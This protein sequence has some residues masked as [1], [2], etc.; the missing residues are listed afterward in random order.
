MTTTKFNRTDIIELAL[1]FK[2][3]PQSILLQIKLH[4]QNR[5]GEL[6]TSDL[7]DSVS[8]FDVAY[9]YSDQSSTWQ[10][11]NS[12]TIRLNALIKASDYSD[13]DKAIL[14]GGLVRNEKTLDAF[15]ERFPITKI[16]SGTYDAF[17]KLYHTGKYDERRLQGMMNATRKLCSVMDITGKYVDGKTAWTKHT[18]RFVFKTTNKVSLSK[19]ANKFL[20]EQVATGFSNEDIEYLNTI[21]SAFSVCVNVGYANNPDWQ[22]FTTLP[23]F[24]IIQTRISSDLGEYTNIHYRLGADETGFAKDADYV[25]LQL[26]TKD[27]IET[28]FGRVEYNRKKKAQEEPTV[29]VGNAVAM[30]QGKFA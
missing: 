17:I 10:H 24:G 8:K 6:E 29:D 18:P 3:L 2:Y 7:I 22:T 19:Q 23:Y 13:E 26:F 25:S 9:M 20:Q 21:S 4:E 30:L 27:N 28:F 11:G 1:G 5:K 14:A 15:A 12:E 16:V